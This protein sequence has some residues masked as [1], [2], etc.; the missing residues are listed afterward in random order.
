[1]PTQATEAQRQKFELNWARMRLGHEGMMLEKI[2]RQNRIVEHLAAQTRDGKFTGGPVP[3]VPEG[4]D[5]GVSI[6]NETHNHYAGAPKSLGSLG[7]L[8]V[9]ASLL[10][11]GGGV[12][13][14]VSQLL[15]SNPPLPPPAV[16][17]TDTITDVAFPK[18][19]PDD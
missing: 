15:P 13:A 11:G 9:A 5:M 7:K 17:D 14:L 10:A 1:M 6:G 4:E 18:E 8:V 3:S 16:V 19:S 2:Q 12:G